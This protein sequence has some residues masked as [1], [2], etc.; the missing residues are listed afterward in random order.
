MNGIEVIKKLPNCINVAVTDEGFEVLFDNQ[1]FE[2]DAAFYSFSAYS[3]FGKMGDPYE[4]VVKFRS[5]RYRI[6]RMIYRNSLVNV[7][8]E[9][10]KN[11]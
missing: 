10:C 9:E 1:H 3:L 5:K 2:N 4:E 7:L 11:N 6:S 8:L